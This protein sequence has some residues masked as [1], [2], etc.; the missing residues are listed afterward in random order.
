MRSKETFIAAALVAGAIA[1]ATSA[2]RS[3]VSV[4]PVPILGCSGAFATTEA[5]GAPEAWA[6]CMQNDANAAHGAGLLS[7]W[8]GHGKEVAQ[9]VGCALDGAG[10]GRMLALGMAAAG[11]AW[12]AAGLAAAALGCL[13]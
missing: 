12:A 8:Q 13:A 9:V 11:G 5:Y 6:S 2:A 4:T 7:W 1:L 10:I 3:T